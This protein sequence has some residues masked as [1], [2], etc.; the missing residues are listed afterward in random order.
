MMRL[1]V[2]RPVIRREAREVGRFLNHVRT[3][4]YLNV[5]RAHRAGTRPVSEY[6]EL[7]V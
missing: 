5:V 6:E 1:L 2:K 7:N 4:N 3:T